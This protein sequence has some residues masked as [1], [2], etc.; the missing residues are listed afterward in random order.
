MIN[1]CHMDGRINYYECSIKYVQYL[2]YNPIC[3]FF[4]IFNKENAGHIAGQGI[5]G[6]GENILVKAL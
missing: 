4:I 1:V 6:F 3:Q 5:R 2:S